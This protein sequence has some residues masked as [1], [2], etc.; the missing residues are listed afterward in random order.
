VG[1]PACLR[2][3]GAEGQGFEV[4]RRQNLNSLTQGQF[5]ARMGQK[6]TLHTEDF[7]SFTQPLWIVRV[8]DVR[9]RVTVIVISGPDISNTFLPAQVPKL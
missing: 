6:Q 2:V 7:P 3:R 9:D 4:L 8:N 1:C 5:R